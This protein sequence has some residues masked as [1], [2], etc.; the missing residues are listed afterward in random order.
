MSTKMLKINTYNPV[1]RAVYA[2]TTPNDKSHNG[3]IKIGDTEVKFSK[4]MDRAVKERIYQQTGTSNTE[5]G[6]K[7]LDMSFWKI[8]SMIYGRLV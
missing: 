5:T 7:W 1:N 3:W 4:D 8:I 6:I 2:Y